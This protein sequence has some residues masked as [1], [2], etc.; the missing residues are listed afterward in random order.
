MAYVYVDD[1]ILAA[2]GSNH[3]LNCMRRVLM[4]TNDLMFCP[5]NTQDKTAGGIQAVHCLHSELHSMVVGLPGDAGLFS[6]L[7]HALTTSDGHCVTLH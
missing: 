2:Q 6:Q 3:K 1:K 4:H 5:N 7:Q